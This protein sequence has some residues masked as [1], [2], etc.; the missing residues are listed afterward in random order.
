MLWKQSVQI[1]FQLRIYGS[2]QSDQLGAWIDTEIWCIKKSILQGCRRPTGGPPKSPNWEYIHWDPHGSFAT[3]VDN[4][5][6]LP[7]TFP[8]QFGYL[9]PAKSFLIDVGRIVRKPVRA[10]MVMENTTPAIVIMEPAIV[11]RR[12]IAPSGSHI[13][14]PPKRINNFWRKED[15]KIRHGH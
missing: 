6:T 11:E 15:V 7:Q 3:P 14:Q 1:F 10:T 4:R 8:A 2:D 9:D 13:A 5:E 12:V